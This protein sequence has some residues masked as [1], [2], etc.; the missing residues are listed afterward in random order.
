[1]RDEFIEFMLSLTKICFSCRLG[2]NCINVKFEKFICN[3]VGNINP[4]NVNEVTKLLVF[5]G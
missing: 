2:V 3:I 5:Y 1:M 4:M